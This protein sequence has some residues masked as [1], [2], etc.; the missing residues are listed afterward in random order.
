MTS[1][2]RGIVTWSGFPGAPGYSTFVATIGGGMPAALKT[3]FEA[4][5]GYIPQNTKISYPTSGDIFTVETGEVTGVWTGTDPGQTT[6]VSTG[7]Y[8]APAGASITWVTEGFVNSR[9]VKGR[10]YIVPLTKDAFDVDGSLL[11]TFYTLLQTSASA[12]VTAEA[13]YFQIWH[14]PV[15]GTGGSIHPVKG[16][17]VRDR[18]SVLTTRRPS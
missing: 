11:P 8:G 1:A 13:D 18:V 4:I 7:T 3:F 5:K 12:L 10:T 16:A 14:R 17:T 9:R 6:C 2:E 15:G